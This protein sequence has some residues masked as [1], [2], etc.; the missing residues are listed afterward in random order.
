MRIESFVAE[1]IC[2]RPGKKLFEKRDREQKNSK[3]E[4]LKLQIS[5]QRTLNKAIGNF[6]A[7]TIQ[8]HQP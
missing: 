4:K 8:H 6:Y 5:K 1:E 2:I 7:P 3:E